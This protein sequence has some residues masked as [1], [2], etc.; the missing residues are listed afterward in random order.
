MRIKKIL[1]IFLIY[2]LSISQIHSIEPDI[3]VQ[4]TVNRA[5]KVLSS[6]ISKENKIKEFDDN[7]EE[8][9]DNTSHSFL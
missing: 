1:F 2:F 3:F 4:S 7:D 9:K 8:D 5:S 6:N